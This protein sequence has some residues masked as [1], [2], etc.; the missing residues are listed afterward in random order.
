[1]ST[2]TPDPVVT[3]GADPEFFIQD[4]NK[5]VSNARLRELTRIPREYNT[6]DKIANSAEGLVSAKKGHPVPLKKVFADKPQGSTRQQRRANKRKPWKRGS[7][8]NIAKAGIIE[9]N[10]LL[11]LNFFEPFTDG[12]HLMTATKESIS[13]LQHYLEADRRGIVP[14]TY[15]MVV[16]GMDTQQAKENGCKPDKSA[17]EGGRERKPVDLH[18]CD[19]FAGGH[20]HVGAEFNCPDHVAVMF[21]ELAFYTMSEGEG[22]SHSRQ[23]YVPMGSYRKKPYGVEL[24]SMNNGWCFAHSTWGRSALDAVYA[25]AKVLATTDRQIIRE[26]FAEVDWET[27]IECMTLESKDSRLSLED[28]LSVAKTF[29][30]A[31]K[32]LVRKDKPSANPF[33][34]DRHGE[35]LTIREVAGARQ[36]TL[37][38][39][40]RIVNRTRPRPGRVHNII[41]PAAMRAIQDDMLWQARPAVAQE[42]RAVFNEARWPEQAMDAVEARHAARAAADDFVDEEF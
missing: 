24:R 37:N 40:I 25:M 29:I 5:F 39:R 11:E 22:T 31:V 36:S 32:W 12:D 26:W 38:E 1:M 18:E 35:H 42:W 23:F 21:L 33:Y 28:K 3:L 17:Y 10:V 15:A 8:K 4:H 20:I 9:D 13:Y 2:E 7:M 14:M 34:A 19:R 30:D 6:P 27:F 41:G 16:D